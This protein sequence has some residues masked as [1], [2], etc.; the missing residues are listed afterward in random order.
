[1]ESASKNLASQ[2]GFPKKARKKKLLKKIFFFNYAEEEL[3]PV[4]YRHVHLVR[5]RIYVL[6]DV[7]VS[8]KAVVDFSGYVL[9]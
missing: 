9:K 4:W 3:A 5:Y 6:L 1:M 8:Q 7:L 2:P